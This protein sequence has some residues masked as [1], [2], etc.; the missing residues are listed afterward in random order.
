MLPQQ[1]IE[2]RHPN[3]LEVQLNLCLDSFWNAT[4]QNRWNSLIPSSKKWSSQPDCPTPCAQ[5]ILWRGDIFSIERLIETCGSVKT[6]AMARNHLL[7]FAR[8]SHTA[9]IKRFIS[10]THGYYK[11]QCL[12]FNEISQPLMG[13]EQPFRF[14]SKNKNDFQ[15]NLTS[16]SRL[17][18]SHLS[19]VINECVRNQNHATSEL[20]SYWEISLLHYNEQYKTRIEDVVCAIHLK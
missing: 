7:D 14:Y 2:L 19:W 1:A 5:E 12:C 9:I 15:K 11:E 6:W 10:W 8:P 18:V 13:G 20:D 4:S 17:P 16:R 3:K